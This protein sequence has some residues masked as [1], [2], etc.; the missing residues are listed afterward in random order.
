MTVH[1]A[2]D[3]VTANEDRPAGAGDRS[4]FRVN[5]NV[6]A[7]R[8]GGDVVLV[9]LRTN[10]ICELTDTSART[11]ELLTS[12]TDKAAVIAAL[13]SEFDVEPARLRAELDDFLAVLIERELI[14][15]ELPGANDDR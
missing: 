1:A 9:H 5:P 13:E 8:M 2:T 12:G 7:Q 10:Q 11:W 3:N 14:E 6:V 4:R 15:R